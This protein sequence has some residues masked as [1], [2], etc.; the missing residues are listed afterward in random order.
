MRNGK[1]Y[2]KMYQRE[3]YNRQRQEKMHCELCNCDIIKHFFNRHVKTKSHQLNFLK[4]E[5][6]RLI[7]I[8]N[9]LAPL[10]QDDYNSV[11]IDGLI[12]FSPEEPFLIQFDLDKSL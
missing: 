5:N 9:P 7:Q 8:L 2:N 12:S 3:L 1:E 4:K 10:T 6:E 11:K